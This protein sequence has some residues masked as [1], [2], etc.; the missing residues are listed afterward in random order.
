VAVLLGVVVRV[1]VLVLVMALLLLR[2]VLRSLC[3]PE[4]GLDGADGA[5]HDVSLVRTCHQ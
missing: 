5:V 4:S 1:P 2:L 3:R